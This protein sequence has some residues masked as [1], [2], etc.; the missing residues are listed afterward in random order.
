MDK[1]N[2][3]KG[4]QSKRIEIYNIG[5]TDAVVEYNLID[6]PTIM[7]SRDIAQITDKRHSDVMRDIRNQ[8]PAYC[9]VYGGQRKF[10]QSSYTNQQNKRQPEYQLTKSQALFVISGYDDVVRAKILKRMEQLEGD[11]AIQ[12]AKSVLAQDKRIQEQA[13]YIEKTKEAVEF[14]QAVSGVSDGVLIG[15]FAKELGLG[16]NKL[17]YFLRHNHRALINGGREHNLPYQHQ[18]DIGRF[19]TKASKP[20]KCSYTG[21]MRQGKPTTLITGK[22][23][24]WVTQKLLE[25]GL[26]K[27]VTS[28]PIIIHQQ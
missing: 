4:A 28:T 17:F 9:E 18:I 16:V 23:K 27:P 14:A 1:K 3:H 6:D 19:T 11:P 25:A 15:E 2:A 20:Y 24:L 26:L 7:S 8:E 21:Q 22:G 13:S 10:A 5:T 12:L